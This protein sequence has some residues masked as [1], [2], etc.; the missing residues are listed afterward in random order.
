MSSIGLS[1]NYIYVINFLNKINENYEN[2]KV[3]FT[4]EIIIIIHIV[5]AVMFLVS[6]V[7]YI[8]NENCFEKFKE[9]VFKCNI[10]EC[11]ECKTF[12]CDCDLG[13]C[14]CL[15]CL[16]NCGCDCKCICFKCSKDNFNNNHIPRL[17]SENIYINN[18]ETLGEIQS[19]K[20]MMSNMITKTNQAFNEVNN[21]IEEI[22]NNMTNQNKK[23]FLNDITN[24]YNKTNDEIKNEISYIKKDIGNIKNDISNIKNL[25]NTVC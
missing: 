22:K 5:V 16:K 9:F 19:L 23:K 1:M 15:K 8:F 13:E 21:N 17:S 25:C 20:G 11:G 7:I 12:K 3:N 6:A 18:T 10:C 2:N 24:N 4:W 14:E